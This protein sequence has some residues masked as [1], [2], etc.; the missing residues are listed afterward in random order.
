MLPYLVRVLITFSSFLLQTII[1]TNLTSFEASNYFRLIS[2]LLLTVSLSTAG[3]QNFIAVKYEKGKENKIDSHL[4]EI[5]LI[6]FS[7]GLIF[8]L[9]NQINIYYA[10]L[11]IINSISYFFASIIN[12]KGFSS[13][14][15]FL[16]NGI[17]TIFVLLFL[18]LNINKGEA[19]FIIYSLGGLVSLIVSSVISK[20]KI[21]YLKQGQ[22]LQES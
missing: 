20:H 7:V 4:L 6:S 9:Q 3:I 16:I 19:L 1:Y 17:N 15:L 8:Y 2:I 5:I 18:L 13:L 12:A 14:Y 11:I 10:L 21:N 22:H